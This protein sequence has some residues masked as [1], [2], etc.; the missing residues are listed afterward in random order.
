[1]NS[2]LG[3]EGKEMCICSGVK[4]NFFL[5]HF[6][7]EQFHCIEWVSSSGLVVTT[8]HIPSLELDRNKADFAGGVTQCGFSFETFR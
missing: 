8:Y 5:A 3:Q 1:M 2:Q 7:G 6:P 4:E